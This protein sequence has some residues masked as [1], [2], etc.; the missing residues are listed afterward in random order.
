MNDVIHQINVEKV[1]A[2]IR[3]DSNLH[4]EDIVRSLY[5]GG[6]RAVEVTLNTPG[7]LD[8]I[9]QLK[10]SFSDMVI[11]AGTVLDAPSAYSAILAGADF[12]LAPTLQKETILMGSRHGVP[13]IPGVM[14]PTEALKAYE[15]G[16]QTVKVFPARS[17][18]VNFAKDVKGPMPFLN[19]MAVGGVS[20]EN[21]VEYFEKGWNSIGVGGSL[22]NRKLI[23]QRNFEEIT[24]R[25]KQFIQ[26][27]DQKV[28]K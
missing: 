22:I 25:A 7:A 23:D 24:D 8:S 27:R 20:L 11:G 17:V 9:K 12:L 16:A 4:I 10:G 2:I 1:V 6:I 26:L 5:E 15:Y 28:C 19:V 21:A 14:T 3:L 18:G 13:V